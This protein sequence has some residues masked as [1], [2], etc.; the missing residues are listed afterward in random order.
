MENGCGYVKTWEKRNIH[1]NFGFEN[2][3]RIE[4]SFG[5]ES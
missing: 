2:K 3:N 5:T 4:T 1:A